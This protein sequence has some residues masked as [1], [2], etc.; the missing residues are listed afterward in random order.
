MDGMV[1]GENAQ[2]VPLGVV[3]LIYQFSQNLK[4]SVRDLAYRLRI[5]PSVMDHAIDKIKL[6]LAGAVRDI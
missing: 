5:P 2:V 4:L 6:D 1:H 3:V